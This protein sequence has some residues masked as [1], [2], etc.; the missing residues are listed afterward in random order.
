MK[1]TTKKTASKGRGIKAT[2]NL[3]VKAA[4]GG[5]VRGGITV[6]KATDS[7]ST[8]LLNEAFQAPRPGKID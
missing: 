2:R 3:E 4:K 6:T 1:K 7:S 5:R 8:R